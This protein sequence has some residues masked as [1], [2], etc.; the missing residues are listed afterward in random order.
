MRRGGERGA[1]GGSCE[2]AR[3]DEIVH[4]E[5]DSHWR[6]ELLQAFL[7]QP[8][9]ILSSRPYMAEEE[10]ECLLVAPQAVELVGVQ[11]NHVLLLDWLA[12]DDLL[13]ELDGVSAGAHALARSSQAA[14]ERRALGDAHLRWEM[15]GYG[16]RWW[17]MVGGDGRWWEMLSCGG[18][19]DVA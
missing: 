18:R 17:D 15:V 13:F 12:S 16:G 11:G 9:L 5:E 10:M 1:G 14:L 4:I 3:L 2:K 19:V 7:E 6:H 8:A